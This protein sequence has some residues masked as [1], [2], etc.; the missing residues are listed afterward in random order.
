MKAVNIYTLTRTA[1]IKYMRR[2]DRQMTG[3]DYHL[4]VKDW[5]IEGLRKLA[6]PLC[7]SAQDWDKLFFFYSFQIPKLGKEFDL[8]QISEDKVLNIELKSQPVS[9]D[10]IRKQLL[11]NKQYL[12]LLGKD[13]HSFT[14]VSSQNRLLRLTKSE[15]LV[16]ADLEDLRK[17]LQCSRDC[18]LE[19]VEELFGEEKYLLSPLSD[20][21]RFLRRDYFLTFQQRDI[22]SKIIRNIQEAAASGEPAIVQGFTGVP[23]T[24]KTLLLYDLAMFFSDKERVCILHLGAITGEMQR[25]DSL[26]KRID[27]VNFEELK[28][29]ADGCTLICVDEGHK[30]SREL[31]KNLHEFTRE[32]GLPMVITYDDE[33][34]ICPLER[35]T[36]VGE[37]LETCPGYIKY[38]LTNRI[39]T[40]SQLSLFIRNLVCLKKNVRMRDFRDVQIVYANHA[41][42]AG[43]LVQGFVDWGYVYIPGAAGG[44]VACEC[45]GPE[46]FCKEYERVVMVADNRLYYDNQ[47]YL[48]ET[49]QGD[50]QV[51]RLFHGLNRAKKGLALVILGNEELFGMLLGILQGEE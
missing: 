41:A 26:L 48:R 29:K 31:W 4:P 15:R 32:K 24:G 6:E 33:T 38:S 40:N 3:R 25:L 46:A 35:E 44:E 50:Y 8:L 30:M 51:S 42:E 18:T 23:G 16:P 28:S 19:N 11:L 1:Q 5:E 47:G 49:C 36:R 14:Y 27:F 7:L 39:R 12:S 37:I 2:F 43:Y 22:R 10:K 17:V 21:D 13:V 20:P 45:V 9:D 34:A